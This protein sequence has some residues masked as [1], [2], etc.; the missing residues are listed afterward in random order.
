[1]T[2]KMKDSGIEWIG[3]IPEDWEIVKLKH[4]ALDRQAGVWGKDES[5]DNLTN[6]KICIR[7]ADFDYPRMTIRKDR[8]FTLR[9]YTDNEISKCSLQKGDIL[10]EKSG[11]GE[12]TP[13]G[14]TIIWNE[15]FQA[16]YANFIERLRVDKKQIL[17]MFAQFCFFA[18]YGIGGS[19]LYFNQTTGIQNLNITGMMNDL[20]LPTPDLSTQIKIVDILDRKRNQIE[21]IKSTIIKEIQTL[22]DYKKSVITEAVT[23]GLDKNVEMKGSGIEW[24]GQIPKH[25]SLNKIKNCADIF[26]RIGYRGYT[27]NDIVDEGEGAVSLSPSN[28]VNGEV[29]YNNNTFIT[30]EKYNESPEIKVKNG[31]IIMVKTGSSYGKVAFLRNLEHKSTINPQL[32][33]FKTKHIINS[34]LYYF[35]NSNYF[36]YQVEMSVTGGTIPTMSQEKIKNFY[37]MTPKIDEQNRIVAYLD[38]KCEFINDSIAIKQKQLETLEEYKK[39]LIYEYVTGKKEVKDGEET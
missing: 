22:E 19:N 12:K 16:L 6:N 30:W 3:E 11:G 23:R 34:Y 36:D 7:I 18:F 31:D 28:M 8:E 13:V 14:R 39:S 29:M 35:M 1:M 10:I 27:Q 20:R 4:L 37:F 5:Q 2:R 15:D 33:V 17:P 26:G 25:W 9:N 38:A 21:I 32:V 24:I